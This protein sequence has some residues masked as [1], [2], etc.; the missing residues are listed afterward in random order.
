MSSSQSRHVY[1]REQR[2]I[3]EASFTRQSH[4]D[5]TEKERLAKLLNCNLIQISNWFQNHRVSIMITSIFLIIYLLFY[6]VEF[7]NRRN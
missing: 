5:I 3:L 4:P 2:T 1:T 7:E 6:S